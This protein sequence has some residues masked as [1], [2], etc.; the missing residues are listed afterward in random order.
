MSIPTVTLNDGNKIPVIGFGTGSSLYEKDAT[1]YVDHALEAGFS[2]I[3]TAAIYKNE[4]SVGEAIRASGLE[5]SDLW[6]TTKYDGGDILQG[7]QTSLSKLGLKSVDLYLIHFP[8]L[9]SSDFEGAW[10]EFE[11]LKKDGLAKSIGVSN[12]SV[13]DLKTVV[14][15]GSITPSVNQ[16]RLHPY[17][18][19]SYKDLLAY[20]AQHNIVIE[21]YGSLAPITTYPG[22]PVDKVLAT[23]A[24]RIGGTPAQ[25]IFKWVIA[26]G[27][28]VVTTTSKESRLKEYLAVVDLPDLTADEIAAIEEAGAKGPSSTSQAVA[29]C[30]FRRVIW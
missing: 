20:S 9:V 16:I 12:F 11:K 25:V 13:Q 22:G 21:A 19:A 28:V 3:D 7:I 8:R 5:R 30:D 10:E 26:K 29:H 4:S 24:K 27:A 6:V 14:N 1:E 17:N 18:Y 2:H 15:S 23:I